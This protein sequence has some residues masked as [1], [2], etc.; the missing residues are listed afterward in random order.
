MLVKY[1]TV[2]IFVWSPTHL[3]QKL[4]QLANNAKSNHVGV[5]TPTLKTRHVYNKLGKLIKI[6]IDRRLNHWLSQT[7]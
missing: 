6:P 7:L 4:N 2:K 5:H 1:L 3:S